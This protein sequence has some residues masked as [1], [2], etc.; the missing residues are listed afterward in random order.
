MA[1]FL[2]YLFSSNDNKKFKRTISIKKHEIFYIK[3]MP[4]QRLYFW[5]LTKESKYA[6]EV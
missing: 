2:S 5:R 1:T 3:K 6:V 4:Q